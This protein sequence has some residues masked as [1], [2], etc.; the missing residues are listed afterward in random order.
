M[1][2]RE[3][4][5]EIEALAEVDETIEQTLRRISDVQDKL[6]RDVR[7]LRNQID[8]DFNYLLSLI[9]GQHPT[10]GNTVSVTIEA[11]PI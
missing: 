1:T 6:V 5:R 2:E 10:P 4:E 3:E 11:K 7:K 8:H 9:Q